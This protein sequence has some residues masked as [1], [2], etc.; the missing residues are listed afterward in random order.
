MEFYFVRPSSDLH[1]RCL[2]FTMPN[3]NKRS[4]LE[5]EKFI[6]IIKHISFWIFSIRRV[7]FFTSITDL[8]LNLNVNSIKKDA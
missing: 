3:T 8:E 7:A 1:K 4:L 5:V 6:V 2:R